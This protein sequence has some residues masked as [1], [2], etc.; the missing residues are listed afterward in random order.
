MRPSGA[1]IRSR[2]GLS[3]HILA[4]TAMHNVVNIR[5]AFG[6]ITVKFING[7]PYILCFI[8]VLL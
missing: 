1:R 5:R 4:D 6:L 2:R 3:V 7:F 8:Q